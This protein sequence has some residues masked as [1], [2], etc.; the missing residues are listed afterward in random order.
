MQ[1]LLLIIGQ[2]SSPAKETS[3]PLAIVPIMLILPFSPLLETTDVLSVP[4]DLPLLDSSFIHSSF[5]VYFER[6]SMS[7]HMRE[8]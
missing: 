4:M 2:Y 6:E 8:R 7:E 1:P 5:K 3:Y